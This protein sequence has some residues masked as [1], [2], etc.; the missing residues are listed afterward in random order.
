ML[1]EV[2]CGVAGAFGAAVAAAAVAAVS[3]TA[4]AILPAM[5]LARL[6]SFTVCSLDLVAV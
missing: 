4:A 5:R 2:H 3:T 6:V 1:A